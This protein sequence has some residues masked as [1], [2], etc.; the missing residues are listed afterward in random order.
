MPE[1][2]ALSIFRLL[3]SSNIQ[4][5]DMP[6]TTKELKKWATYLKQIR[7]FF[8]S[9]GFTE[10]STDYLV[11]SGAFEGTIDVLHVTFAGGASELHTSPEIE[12]KRLLAKT[13]MSLYQICKCF[14]DDPPTGVHLREF[15]MLEFYR[16]AADYRFVLQDMKE[17]IQQVAGTHLMFE[18]IRMGELFLKHLGIDFECAS[19]RNRLRSL[20]EERE[21]DRTLHR[22]HGRI[23]FLSS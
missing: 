1:G 3:T 6:P 22:G 13:Q 11:P 4:H 19:R 5:A 9:R 7:S 17:L 23:C 20:I 15:T 12:M 18:E 21:F 14:R 2:A 10:V 8:D 16:V